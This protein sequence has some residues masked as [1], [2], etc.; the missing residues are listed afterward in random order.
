MWANHDK[1]APKR[2]P[3][4]TTMRGQIAKTEIAID[5]ADHRFIAAR[6]RANDAPV[7]NNR[8]VFQWLG[9]KPRAGAT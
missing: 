4:N 7:V 6:V 9:S 2:T 8:P 5:A 3:S 1:T